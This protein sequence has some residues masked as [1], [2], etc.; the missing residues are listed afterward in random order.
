MSD[1]DVLLDLLQ[2]YAKGMHRTI[3]D[4]TLDA[5][6][7]QPDPQA[8]NIAVTVWHV[9]RAFDLL[10]VLILENQPPENEL[11]FTCGWAEKTG[12]N[13]I[14]LGFDGFGNLAGYTL[15]EV[16]G[17][18]ILSAKKLLTYFD[19]ACDALYA[20]LDSLANEDIYRPIKVSDTTS[21]PAYIF[22]CSFM[23]DARE[24]LGEIKAIK[25]MWKRK[26]QHA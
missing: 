15:A 23:M 7:W 18:P 2:N 24:H 19:Q 4:L 3:S 8:N 1:K 12:Y 26:Q 20:Y 21:V 22:I 10:K 17:V 25:A 6:K 11:W 14:G 5:L 16:A 9:S 13:P